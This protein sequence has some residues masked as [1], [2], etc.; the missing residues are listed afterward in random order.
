MNQ[1]DLYNFIHSKKYMVLSTV[2]RQGNPESGL[3]AF[4]DTDNLEIIFGTYS[5]TRKYSNLIENPNVS[6]VIGTD[7]DMK[8]IQYEGIVTQVSKDLID[9]IVSPYFTKNPYSLNFKNN[10]EQTYWVI[11]PKWIKYTDYSQSEIF[12]YEIT[13]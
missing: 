9:E 1:K 11:K 6:V 7:D 4:G 5:S 10:L 12:T 3:M 2:N 8:S 13:Y